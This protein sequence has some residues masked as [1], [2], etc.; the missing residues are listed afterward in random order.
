MNVSLRI[1]MKSAAIDVFMPKDQATQIYLRWVARDYALRH[2]H[3]LQGQDLYGYS[4]A[5]KVEEI[6]ALFI[7]PMPNNAPQAAQ[8]PGPWPNIR[9][10]RSGTL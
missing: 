7:M 3:V 2:E 6:N 8:T 1:V 5:V 9:Q 4:Y 10:D